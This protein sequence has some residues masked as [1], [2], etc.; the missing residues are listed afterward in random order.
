MPQP[1]IPIHQQE[2]LSIL[3]GDS[4]QPEFKFSELQSILF[5]QTAS[6]NVNKKYSLN[7]IE[8]LQN[9]D[10]NTDFVV[11]AVTDSNERYCSV[12]NEIDSET[13]LALKAEGLIS[14]HGRSVKITDR[15]RTALRD[16]YLSTKNALM[17]N[18]ASEKFDYNSFARLASKK[19]K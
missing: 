8:A 11:T 13:V 5:Q 4:M 1:I 12:P 17:E 14:G 10:K 19:G 6:S 9:I 7:T 2:S 3:F 15:G 16:A 18:R